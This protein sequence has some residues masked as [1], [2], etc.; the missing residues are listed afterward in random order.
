VNPRKYNNINL[1]SL[2]VSGIGLLLNPRQELFPEGLL[3]GHNIMSRV[4]EKSYS[5]I[6]ASEYVF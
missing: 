4:E 3:K 1:Y 6:T 2:A 5:T